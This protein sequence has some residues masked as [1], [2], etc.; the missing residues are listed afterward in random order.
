MSRSIKNVVRS[1]AVRKAIPFVMVFII[2]A[3]VGGVFT[4]KVLIK[5]DSKTTSGWTG[6]KSRNSSDGA[7]RQNSQIETNY[8][9]AKD[10]VAKDQTS[11]KLTKEQADKLAA[12]ID[13]IYAYRTKD[14][15]DVSS[16]E[17]REQLSAKRAEWRKWASENSIPSRYILRL[18]M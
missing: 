11:S 8:T 16:E 18:S 6:T 5:S 9:R 10:D 15:K 3:V 7:G 1:K 12:K 2:G 14:L 4:H 13:E 17:A